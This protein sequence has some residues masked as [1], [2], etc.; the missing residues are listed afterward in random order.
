MTST[1]VPFMAI[2]YV[3]ACLII[4][5]FN[6]GELPLAIQSIFQEAFS[7]SSVAG[8]M[9]G[10]MIIDFSEQFF[11]MKLVWDPQQL[12]ILQLRQISQ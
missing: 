2:F 6:L 10:V 3:I 1:L 12:H 9:I 7:K 8:G 4:I 5:L 11:Q